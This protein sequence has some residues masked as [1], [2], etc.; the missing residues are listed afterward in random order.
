MD[1]STYFSQNARLSRRALARFAEVEMADLDHVADS[2]GFGTRL[3]LDEAEEL[4]AELDDLTDD[5]DAEATDE[6]AADGQD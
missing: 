5:D 4:L 1:I 3:R 6:D 2:L